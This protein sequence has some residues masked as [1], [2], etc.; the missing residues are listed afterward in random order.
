M[1]REERQQ[2]ELSRVTGGEREEGYG[3]GGG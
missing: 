2:V 3:G 1:I